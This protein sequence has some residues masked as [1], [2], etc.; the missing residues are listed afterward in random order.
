METAV[1]TIPKKSSSDSGLVESESSV[2]VDP[3][4]I[5]SMAHG[6]MEMFLP[7]LQK[8]K[9]QLNEV[10]KVQAISLETVQQENAKFGDT[11]TVKEITA[12]MEEAKRYY[13]KLV[14]L[15]KE[16]QSL[17]DKS[18]KLKRQAVK[19]QQQKQRAEIQ[20]AQQQKRKMERERRLQAKDA[21]RQT[22][23]EDKPAPT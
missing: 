19:L 7:N 16:M 10:L 2:P 3:R 5:E 8:S 1:E 15:K 21:K 23:H 11:D 22:S 14:A 4:V 17:A 20:L 12:T 13:T 18:E 9:S 6:V